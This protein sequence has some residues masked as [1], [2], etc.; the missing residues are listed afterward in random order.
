MPGISERRQGE[1][2]CT[3]SLY[4][5]LR[6]KRSNRMQRLFSYYRF[7]KRVG[8][9]N[10]N[11]YVERY[12]V[13]RSI[14]NTQRITFNYRASFQA[15]KSSAS[16]LWEFPKRIAAA[17]SADGVLDAWIHF[18]HKRKK[19]YHFVL[20]LK[21]L[22]EAK[23]V[24]TSDWRFQ[25]IAKKLLKRSKYF[26]DLPGIC[27]YLGSLRAVPILDKLSI[28][29]SENIDR[30]SPPQLAQIAGAF[31]SCRLSS[32][33]L[34]SLIARRLENNIQHASNGE[35]ATVAMAFGRCAI[36][37][38]RLLASISQEVQ[39]RFSPAL[40]VMNS[41]RDLVS[42]PS[43]HCLFSLQQEVT[44]HAQRPSLA[45][46]LQLVSKYRDSQICDIVSQMVRRN[47]SSLTATDVANP[48]VHRRIVKAFC[49]LKI[50]DIPLFLSILDNIASRPYNYTPACV[51]EIGKHLSLVLP[52]DADRV[53]KVE[54]KTSKIQRSQAFGV[55]L[56]EVKRHLHRMG[57]RELCDA[58]VFA[59][60]ACSSIAA[61]SD[62]M[63][64][65]STMVVRQCPSNV[66]YDAP[67]L[68][69]VLSMHSSLDQ[70]CFN[71]I[72]RDIYRLVDMFEPVDFQ[73]TSRVL[74]KLKQSGLSNLK[75]VNMLS[76][77]VA[78]QWEEFSEYQYHC[79]ARDL[80]L[81][82]PPFQSLLMD[83]W[84][85]NKSVYALSV[86]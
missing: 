64:E 5:R 79:V 66:K 26:I 63:S 81:A 68:M 16:Y 76:K 34:F 62:F 72:C 45:D 67:K 44:V 27:H 31:G 77:R 51:A 80:T 11:R 37:N 49:S 3:G 56:E 21:R 22:S 50:N 70:E 9:G 39:K 86:S 69:E 10:W 32:K 47:M 33:H 85:R 4:S 40:H 75:M 36:Y 20:A 73:R 25:L 8:K 28:V 54:L 48:D 19:A 13:P 38:Y 46:L 35:L 7:H 24:D 2:S 17:T 30:Y 55:C 59:F 65:V 71:L 23:N 41:H 61:K 53:S 12:T 60:K 42:A 83:I 82:G 43:R 1:F 57:R 15:A 18:R 58:A 14:E 29:L 6:F 84:N 74:R 52:R 78:A